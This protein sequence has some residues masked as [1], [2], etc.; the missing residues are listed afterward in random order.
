MI[1]D[2]VTGFVVNSIDQAV[3]AVLQAK[4]LDRAGVEQRS[5]AVSRRSA[6][7]GTIWRFI[8]GSQA[9]VRRPL[10]FR[11]SSLPATLIFTL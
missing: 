11:A 3:E 7:R 1:D 8:E 5:N 10:G 4:A 9:W 6:W 2:G